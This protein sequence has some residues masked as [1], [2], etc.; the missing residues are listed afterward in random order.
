MPELP[1]VETV[2][3]TLSNLI[4][5][6]EIRDIDIFYNKII[7]NKTEQEFKDILIG[8]TI[9]EIDRYGKYLIFNLG[10]TSLISHL[11]ME[12]KYFIKNADEPKGKHEHIIIYFTDGNTLR[13]NDTRKFG[14]MDIVERDKVYVDSPVT[15]LGQEPFSDKMTLKYLKEKLSKKS[16]A[17]KSALL[18]QTI[19]TGLGNI[20]VDEVL[21]LSKLNPETPSNKVTNKD[22]KNIIDNSIKVLNKAIKLGGTTIRSYTSSLGV[23]GRFQNELNVHTKAGEP[24][25]VCNTPIL[26]I[27]VNGRGTYYCDKCQKK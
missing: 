7:R 14:T 26:K 4:L 27:K 10:D 25:P 21:F 6:K 2:R 15:K 11:R 8:K 22:I 20:Y 18:D 12:G 5:G 19:M 24:C 16:I 23:T 17:I 9:D 1:E 3:R 13:Y